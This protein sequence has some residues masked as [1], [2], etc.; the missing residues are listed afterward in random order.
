MLESLYVQRVDEAREKELGAFSTY[1]NIK[2]ICAAIYFNA[3]IIISALVFLLVDKSTLDL[4]KVFSTLALLGY[5]F[6]FRILYSNYAIESLF[7]MT[8]F[9]KRVEDI[10]TKHLAN[11]ASARRAIV[12]VD[13]ARAPTL[14]LNNVTAS[15]SAYDD[16]PAAEAPLFKN[17]SINLQ[18]G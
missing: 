10:V 12:S 7:A 4:G 3:G 8:V 15:W 6:N 5:I 17:L 14:A 16:N 13:D 1:C 18:A 11:T 9:N 2:N